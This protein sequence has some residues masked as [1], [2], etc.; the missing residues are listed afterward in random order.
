MPGDALLDLR[1]REKAFS[2]G[3]PR[4][5]LRDVSFTAGPG[6]VVA[7]LGRSGAGKSTLLRIIL[8]LDRAFDGSVRLPQGRV[9]V[10][11]QEP[12]LLPWLTVE[13]NLRLVV[14]EGAPEPDLARLLETV[15]LPGSARSRPMELSLGMA[16]RV[17]VARAFAV[18]PAML[19]LDEPFVSLDRRLAGTL[20][21]LLMARAHDHGTLVLVAMHDIE[22]ALSIADRILVLHGQPASL[23]A[24]LQVPDRSDTVAVDRLRQELLS[25]FP[26]LG[27][28]DEVE[29]N[30]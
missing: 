2:G 29:T 24:D 10:V 7:L 5:V 23:T 4:T 9:G 15:D 19:V 25:R 26:F 22:H 28:A 11:F 17:A 6:E 27:E 3:A 30:L 21:T 8:G 13:E 18:D 1:I 12:R 14:T 16:R 20:G